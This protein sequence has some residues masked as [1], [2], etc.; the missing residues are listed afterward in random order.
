MSVAH[1]GKTR[2]LQPGDRV[3]RRLELLR[4][5]GAGGM[6]TVWAARNLTTGA[7]V[8]IKLLEVVGDDEAHA[9]ERFR[10]E[11]KLGAMLAHRNITRVFDLHED[12]GGALVLVME[13]LQGETLEAWYKRNGTL[14][15]REAVGVIVPILGALQ[16]AHEHGVVHRD[17]KPSNIFLHIDPDGHVTP[18][19][20]D[21]GIAK[22]NDSSVETRAGDALGTPSYMSPEQVRASKQL[23]GRSDVFSIGVVLYEI[24]T[25]ENP[26]H[27]QTSSAALAHVL[28]LEIDPDPRI[29]PRVWL[30][31]QRALSKQ[32]YERHPSAG[33]LAEALSKAIGGPVE[34]ARRQP[35]VRPSD[36]PAMASSV[37]S[38]PPSN[39]SRAVRSPRTARIAAGATLTFLTAAVV[40]IAAVAWLRASPK[41]GPNEPLPTASPESSVSSDLTLTAEPVVAPTGRTAPTRHIRSDPAGRPDSPRIGAKK[42]DPAFAPPRSGSKATPRSAPAPSSVAAVPSASAAASAPPIARTPGF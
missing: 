40:L 10:H 35:P 19:L 42:S 36:E 24:L 21:F 13:L 37:P 31:V 9:A 25:G 27:A 8:A 11:A 32:A 2:S 15:N 16:Q 4:P 6:G 28:E 1:P 23:D 30:E 14:S 5:L 38:R 33:A 26:F 22:T 41:V 3:A 17:L 18:K 34:L 12:E 7:E 39:P 29:E 20:L